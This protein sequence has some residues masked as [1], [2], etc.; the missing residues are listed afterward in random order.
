MPR[1][2]ATA[3]LSLFFILGHAQAGEKKNMSGKPPH[4]SA[5]EGLLPAG[6][7]PAP[8]PDFHPAHLRDARVAIVPSAN[9]NQWARVWQRWFEESGEKFK[10]RE[11]NRR[12]V[13]HSTN[14]R[15][16]SEQ[17]MQALQPHVGQVFVADDLVQAR[18]SGADY[19]LILDGWLGSFSRW[20]TYLHATGS[21][22]LLD[23]NL[24]RALS[25]HG[26][27]KVKYEEPPLLQSWSRKAWEEVYAE[28]A[29]QAVDDMTRQVVSTLQLQL[30]SA[31]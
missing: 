4:A 16:F 8:A 17:V 10:V 19:Y 12:N 26:E 14:P 1:L 13:E 22:E 2:F 27:A 11:E 20:N 6:M 23:G 31:H 5:Y 28:N 21:V 30:S 25:A 29:S 9:F 3:L 7:K 15:N 24:Q 18:D